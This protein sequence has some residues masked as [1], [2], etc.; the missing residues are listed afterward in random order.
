MKKLRVFL[1]K[2]LSSMAW[3]MDVGWAGATR[4]RKAVGLWEAEG[5]DGRSV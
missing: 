2:V 5:R 3:R 4:S 1:W